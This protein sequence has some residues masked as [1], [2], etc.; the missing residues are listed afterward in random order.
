VAV[1]LIGLRHAFAVGGFFAL[2]AAL[3][4]MVRGWRSA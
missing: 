2:G 1:Y 3:L 4:S